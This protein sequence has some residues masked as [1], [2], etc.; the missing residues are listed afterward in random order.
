MVAPS[1]VAADQ[2]AIQAVRAADLAV[3][4]GVTARRLQVLRY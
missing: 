4:T 2:L 3:A 1:N